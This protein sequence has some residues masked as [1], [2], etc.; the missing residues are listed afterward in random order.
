[1]T[2]MATPRVFGVTG[3]WCS[4]V[5]GKTYSARAQTSC[6][7]SRE[8]H[9]A[10]VPIF[11]RGVERG[12]C[13]TP[14][15]RCVRVRATRRWQVVASSDA[16]DND[17][18]NDSSG[19]SFGDG[20]STRVVD[21]EAETTSSPQMPPAPPKR[22]RGRPKGTRKV[23]NAPV[24]G[25]TLGVASLLWRLASDDEALNGTARIQPHG[26]E[27]VVPTL[28]KRKDGENDDRENGASDANTNH[29]TPQG[30]DETTKEDSSAASVVTEFERTARAKR[31][32]GVVRSSSTNAKNAKAQRERWA[33]ARVDATA[34]RTRYGLARF[35]NSA[36][37]VCP[38]SYQKGRLTSADCPPVITHTHYERLTLFLFFSA[39][40]P[41]R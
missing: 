13:G 36:V 9:S 31:S 19:V 16:L 27:A 15:V 4:A 10:R 35:P 30:D 34:I 1:M 33:K 38:Y 12:W 5:S 24:P 23:T 17:D 3:G 32:A 2:A 20:V 22:R 18:A 6:R 26:L 40:S 25:D 14:P 11:S 37:H 21:P 28:K 8:T 7:A 29:L 41:R 39:S